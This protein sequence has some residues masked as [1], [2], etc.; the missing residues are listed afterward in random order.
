MR[1]MSITG[2]L[3]SVVMLAGGLLAPLAA[4]PPAVTAVDYSEGLRVETSSTY[5]VDLAAAVIHAEQ[6]ITLTNEVPD[7]V[8]A[9]YIEQSYF[10][11]YS[12]LVLPG[13]TNVVAS[14]E[15][16][17]GLPVEVAPADGALA[18]VA[19]IDLVP[20]LYYGGAKTVRLSYDLPAQ[21]PRSG[22]VAQVNQA[23]ATLPV[24]TAADP[25]LGSV[26]VVLPAG[27]DVEVAGSDLTR[28]SADGR[29]TYTATGIADP[30]TWMATII[31]RDDAALVAETV[32]FE[33]KGVRI[34][35]WPG[36]TEW[37]AFTAD[38]VERGLPALKSAI[39]RPWLV[40]G[41]LDV[42]ET[43]APYVYGYAG[44]YEHA[45]SLIEVGD[46]LDAHVTLHEMAHAWFNGEAFDGRWVNEALADEFAALA[47][48]ELGMERPLPEPVDPAAAAAVPLNAWAPPSL[49]QG[50][51]QEQEAYGYAASWWV[52]HA[53]VEEIGADG[54]SAV[55][56]A[57]LDHDNPYPA[58]SVDS[59]LESWPDWRTFLD[60]LE[61]V[62][63][64]TQ[65]SELFRTFVASGEDLALLD[66][67][68]AA[69]AAYA[70]LTGAGDGWAP[71]AVLRQ[72]MA[73]WSFDD[74]TAMM[75]QVHDAFGERDAIA[76]SLATIELAV[77]TALRE[78]LE[79]AEDLADLDRALAEA[80]R[81]ADALVEATTAEAGANPL[82]RLGLVVLPVGD[83]LDDARAA[84]EAGAWADATESAR[85]ASSG[86]GSATTVGG[87]VLGGVLVAALVVVAVVR[88]RR[89]PRGPGLPG[90]AP[91]PV[92]AAPV[93]PAL[94]VPVGAAP[95]GSAPIGAAPVGAVP[96]PPS[97]PASGHPVPPPPPPP[98]PPAPTAPPA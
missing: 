43:S 62:G 51:A 44:W 54:M 79:G 66:A 27:L 95:V 77:P 64:S 87:L 74:A 70:E 80:G 16:G 29:V 12:T 28:S 19:T 98:P 5:T 20:D 69:R 52:A 75:P 47:M 96:P 94:P 36:D 59:P 2:A 68:D 86:V 97:R 1:A 11:E 13:A 23:F 38:L 89:R 91:M 83:D 45:R 14:W 58:E 24:F 17:R 88:L 32:F 53:L 81:A 42:V 7:R 18:S 78:D 34:Q 8:T 6:V 21:P 67:R 92:P 72:A 9:S 30:D 10:P 84:L 41:Q 40:E 65:A 73:A 55:V 46:A 56:N 3:T 48:S 57:A 39:G 93:P 35:A 50:G 33:D 26:T 85:A 60:H 25:G 63:G 82:A 49:D 61:G 71:P 76:D 37:L 15:G 4:A 90:D 22:A 31:A